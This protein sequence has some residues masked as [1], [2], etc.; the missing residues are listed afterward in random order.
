[1]TVKNIEIKNIG[2][3]VTKAPGEGEIKA[4]KKFKPNKNQLIKFFKSSEESKENKWLHEYYSSC[5]STG[6]VEFENGV[7]GEWVLQSSGLGRVITDNN[8]S[9]YFFQKDNSRE[10]P[11]AGTYGLDN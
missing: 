6:N 5:V 1:M 10:D 11:M 4:C 2:I 8:D 9:I 7:S 3:T